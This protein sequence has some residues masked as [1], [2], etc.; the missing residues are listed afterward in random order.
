MDE[1]TCSTP[2]KRMMKVP[3]PKSIEDLKSPAF[4][5]LIKA[6]YEDKVLSKNSGGD[7]KIVASAIESPNSRQ[8]FSA[9]N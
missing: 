5:E 3:S 4:D 7:L 9:I 8:P 2:R 1:P 6:F